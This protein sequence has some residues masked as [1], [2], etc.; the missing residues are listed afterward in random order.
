MFIFFSLNDSVQ[1]SKLVKKNYCHLFYLNNFL[2]IIDGFFQE[3]SVEHNNSNLH[4]WYNKLIFVTDIIVNH[5]GNCIR[6][7]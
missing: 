2:L 4:Y 5:L 1:F 7:V 3:F 6:K